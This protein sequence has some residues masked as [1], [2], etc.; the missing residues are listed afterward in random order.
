MN[1]NLTH[2]WTFR[3]LL[4]L[5]G[6][7]IWTLI[8]WPLPRYFQRAIPFGDRVSADDS[9]LLELAPGD[10][11]QLYYHFW[12]ARD[13]IAGR[14]PPF[15]NI[16]EFNM[17]DGAAQPA[18]FDPYYVPFSLV[19]AAVSPWLGDAAGWNFASLASIFLG[20]FGCY[21]LAQRYAR[22]RALA[23]AVALIVTA[24]PYRWITLLGGSPTGFG[25]GLIPWLLVGLDR[26]VRDQRPSGGCL[27]GLALLGAYCTDLHTF[28]F[29]VLL[30]PTWCI[31]AWFTQATPG[32]I[33]VRSRIR[34]TFLALLPTLF[35]AAMALGLSIMS[36]RQLAQ[37][38]MAEG[39]TWQEIKLFSPIVSGLFRWQHLGPSNH[40]FFGTA[41]TALIVAGFVIRGLGWLR[42]RE[43][44]AKA[45][46]A[47]A[48]FER[49]GWLLLAVS[50]GIIAIILLA[51][52]TYGPGHGLPLKAARRLLPKYTMIRQTA[53]IFCLMP[54]LLAILLSLLYAGLPTWPQAKRR[55]LVVL[56]VLLGATVVTESSLWFRAGLCVLPPT[57][58]AYEAAAQHAAE[59][60]GEA[61]HGVAIPLWPGDSHYSSVYEYGIIRSRVRLLNGY[62][63][64]VP[65]GY[66]ERVGQALYGLN[67]GSLTEAEETLL[68][69]MSV[70]Y[71]FFHEQPYPEKVALFPSGI[72][73]R[74]LLQNPHLE[75]L[76]VADAT[77]CFFI[78]DSPRPTTETDKLWGP[79]RYLPAL[80]WLPKRQPAS[81]DQHFE[82][83]LTLRAP[84]TPAPNLRYL[85]RLSGGGSLTNQLGFNIEVP[86]EAVWI[87]A[88][89]T[90]PYGDIW[91]VTA[92]Q[93]RLEHALIVAGDGAGA[94]QN[95]RYH[96]AAA[97]LFHRGATDTH[98]GSVSLDPLRV[99]RGLVLYGP[100]LPFPA[101]RYRATLTTEPLLAGNHGRAD[102]DLLVTTMGSESHVIG[103]AAVRAGL[104]ASCEFD[105][106]GARPLR[107]EY[108]YHRT[109]ALRLLAFD[110]EPLNDTAP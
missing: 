45:L 73:L 49:S 86:H 93:P 52:G 57:M 41:L 106:D 77:R 8:T 44:S 53:K 91:H 27:A 58:P 4:C 94:L 16:Y 109:L 23:L 98:N 15:N 18:R 56:F 103:H 76:A 65:E 89:M 20:L 55:Y 97:D 82:F 19:F 7:A 39:R 84:A 100:N 71:L 72:A 9:P 105:Y 99:A 42:A 40:I 104:P 25:I 60:G 46:A 108:H 110:L 11:L 2:R 59:H 10:H 26:A 24:F 78:R 69:T 5:G 17:G 28:Y 35:L 12:L 51:F 50:C 83:A 107:L 92:G 47:P 43:S 6:L 30:T 85:M 21:V 68:R 29:S 61:P 66:P 101:G 75:P 36:S 70:R 34:A 79:P 88:P 63:P 90:L 37:T 13:M 102:G 62:A 38:G 3:A 67:G 33:F 14:T 95:G 31:V 48:R 87:E 96:W 80:H 1:V 74:R 22:S 81:T 64:A 32:P 54:A